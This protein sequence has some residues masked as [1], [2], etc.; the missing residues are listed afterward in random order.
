MALAFLNP[1]RWLAY[2]AGIIG[3]VMLIWFWVISPYNNHVSAKAVAAAIK[4]ERAKTQPII[5]ELTN[6]VASADKTITDYKAASNKLKAKIES[7]QGVLNATLK[8]LYKSENEL[9]MLRG[10]DAE[11]MRLLDSATANIGSASNASPVARLGQL[12]SAHHQ[13]QAEFREERTRHA[14]TIA[15]LEQALAMIDALK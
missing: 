8:K 9:A 15:G 13:C 1:Y 3:I 12:A 2:V 7:N 5:D 11:F 10:S 6:R 14:K 4:D